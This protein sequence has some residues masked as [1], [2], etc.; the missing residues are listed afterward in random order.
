MQLIINDTEYPETNEVEGGY[1]KCYREELGESLRMISGRRIHEVRGD[2]TIIEYSFPYFEDDM[3]K[4]AMADLRSNTEL[5]VLY[6]DPDTL[7]TNSGFFHCTTRPVPE[8]LMIHD[9]KVYWKNITF[10]L[11]EVNAHIY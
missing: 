5:F 4:Q 10:K 8:F 11:E 9:N 3:M 2:A 7:E 6:Q 1:F